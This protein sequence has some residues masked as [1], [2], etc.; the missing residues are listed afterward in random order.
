MKSVTLNAA[1]L[2][3]TLDSALNVWRNQAKIFTKGTCKNYMEVKP[4]TFV[5]NDL[6]IEELVL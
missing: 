1:K 6:N 5:K 4:I 3:S 2:F